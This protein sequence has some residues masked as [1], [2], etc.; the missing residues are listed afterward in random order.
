M[1]TYNYANFGGHICAVS[2]DFAID[3]PTGRKI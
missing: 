1:K 3:L 2:Q